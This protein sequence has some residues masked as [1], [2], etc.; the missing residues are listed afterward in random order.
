MRLI[1]RFQE[2]FGRIQ[3]N[4]EQS[5]Q[6]KRFNTPLRKANPR[7]LPGHLVINDDEPTA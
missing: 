6:V 4:S 2:V 3:A 1:V 7:K 5:S